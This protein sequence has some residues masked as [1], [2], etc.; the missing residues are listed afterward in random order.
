MFLQRTEVFLKLQPTQEQKSVLFL[1]Y[2]SH[3]LLSCKKV[4]KELS[5]GEIGIQRTRFHFFRTIGINAKSDVCTSAAPFVHYKSKYTSSRFQ[6]CVGAIHESPVQLRFVNMRKS[7]ENFSCR[8][9]HVPS[10]KSHQN[11][12][13]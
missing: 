8:N 9:Y 12:I 6:T 10:C 7:K 4:C 11:M 13:Q 2:S 3:N 1:L 5:I